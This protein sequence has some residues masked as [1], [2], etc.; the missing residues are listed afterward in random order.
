[1]TAGPRDR[2]VACPDYAAGPYAEARAASALRDVQRL[3]ACPHAHEII[4]SD[5]PPATAGRWWE[6]EDPLD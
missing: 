2:W 5:T 3:G 1:M 6:K 4:V